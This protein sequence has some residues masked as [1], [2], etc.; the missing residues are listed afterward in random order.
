MPRIKKGLYRTPRGTDWVLFTKRTEEPKLCW[1][2]NKLSAARI[3]WR[4]AGESFHAPIVEVRKR[5]LD[6]A[7][8]I[9]DKVDEVPDDAPRFRNACAKPDIRRPHKRR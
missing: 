5:D 6:R 1:L 8:D 2:E 4:R 9:L 7:W 3:H